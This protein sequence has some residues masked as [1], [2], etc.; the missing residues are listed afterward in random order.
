MKLLIKNIVKTI[1]VMS[2]ISLVHMKFYLDNLKIPFNTS[3]K[4][5]LISMTSKIR[6][7]LL[8][9]LTNDYIHQQTYNHV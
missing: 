6:F 1:K 8:I 9:I 4:Y 2:S 3:N 5:I 7:L